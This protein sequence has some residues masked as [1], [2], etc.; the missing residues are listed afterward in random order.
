MSKPTYDRYGRMHYHPDFH[1]N[2]KKSWTTK[3]QQYLIDWYEKIGP[4]QVS[5]DLGRTIHVVQQKACMLRKRGLMPK[6]VKASKHKR[7]RFDLDD[8]E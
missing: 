4:D 8:N 1:P 6:P 7:T 2:H 3:D 5:L